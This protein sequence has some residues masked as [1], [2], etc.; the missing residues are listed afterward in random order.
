M[1][2]K[3][4]CSKENDMNKDFI[5]THINKSSL[6]SSSIFNVSIPFNT[7]DLSSALLIQSACKILQFIT[8]DQ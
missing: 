8:S 3:P 1:K 5:D 2:S 7:V 6:S 4:S